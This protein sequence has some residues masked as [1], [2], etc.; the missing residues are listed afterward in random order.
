MA[1]SHAS[2]GSS[3]SNFV[4]ALD[5]AFSQLS[6][7]GE[8]Q[9]RAGGSRTTGM[10][11]PAANAAVIRV[12]QA[13]DALTKRDYAAAQRTAAEVAHLASATE[14]VMLITIAGGVVLSLFLAWRLTSSLLDPIRM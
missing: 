8:R 14:R 4:A 11:M 2:V 1:Q 6:E 7:E 13:I 3:R 5:E 10:G 9:L 12:Y